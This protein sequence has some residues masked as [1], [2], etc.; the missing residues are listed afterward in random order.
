MTK[1][2]NFFSNKKGATALANIGK[3]AG[4]AAT[5]LAAMNIAA[6][7]FTDKEVTSAE[8]YGQAILKVAN[9]GKEVSSSGLDDVFKDW[10]K[11]FGEER[12]ANVNNMSDAVKMLFHHDGYEDFAK[13]F[14][15]L[16]QV[17]GAN[18]SPL[19][20]VEQRIKG[21]GD[22]M[23][24]LTKNGGLDT[25]AKSFQALSKEYINNGKTAQD[26]LD[27]V[28]GYKAALEGLAN[29][30]GVVVEGQDLID[31]AMGKIPVGM[32]AAAG[33]TKTYTDAAGQSVPMSE[34]MSDAL[35]KIGVTA[36]GTV[37]DLSVF[38]D[39]L[40][41]A[42]L[43]NLSARDAARGYEKAIDDV[44]ESIKENGAT[45]D[46]HTEKGRNNQSALDA[47]A[48]AGLRVV[49][50]NA[51][52]GD[53]QEAL[54]GNLNDT[55]EKLKAS[56]AQFGITGGAADDLA[57]M[58]L[59]VP[60]GVDVKSWMSDE[61]KR[62][63]E[64]TTAA[65][66]GIPKDVGVTVHLYGTEQIQAALNSV[67]ALQH[68]AGNAML[69]AN[70]YASGNAYS[71]GNGGYT[72]GAVASI[73]GMYDGGVIPGSPPSRPNVD[74]ILALVNGKPLKVRS[75]EFITN[76]SQTKA[77]LPWLKA[78][79]E[80]LNLGGAMR[81]SYTAGYASGNIQ[82]PA[83]SGGGTVISNTFN[84]Q[85]NASAAHIA[86]EVGWALRTQ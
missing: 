17:L 51:K 69:T 4:A 79:N 58:I 77:N 86:D 1:I 29:T 39:A 14:D 36:N 63:A 20:E 6:A 47:V 70:R 78:S 71:G 46:I 44:G 84:V 61:A 73:M 59:K 41:N 32:Q 22:A 25:A 18:I 52:N 15:G 27:A 45:L 76:E 19:G 65:L 82:A 37:A 13:Q 40:I 48:S 49:E 16:N 11:T 74:N 54:Q 67:D 12:V 28:P 80:G 53:S 9:S 3:A 8:A 56:A 50:A 57:R 38:T 62:M 85:T 33:A 10:N 5:A 60:P 34:E 68:A 64:K 66:G 31:Y 30:A 81:A 43:M 72:G 7:V 42:G 21:M 55:Y 2:R 75:G 26:A 24:G 23:G 83:Q 35:E